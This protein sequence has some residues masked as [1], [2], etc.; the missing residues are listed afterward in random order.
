M[1]DSIVTTLLSLK[2]SGER[3]TDSAC[4][5][6]HVSNTDEALVPL[7]APATGI[8]SD[9]PYCVTDVVHVLA[10]EVEFGDRASTNVI[11]EKRLMD[12]RPCC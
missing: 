1:A 5:T 12:L 8:A 6:V 11:S 9:A 2:A 10:A 3:L 7:T 4:S